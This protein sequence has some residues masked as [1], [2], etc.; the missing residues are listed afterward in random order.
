MLF[1]GSF[2]DYIYIII[3]LV[4]IVFSIYKG[5]QKNKARK[6]TPVAPE[7]ESEEKE[8]SSIFDSFLNKLMKEEEQVPYE[9]VEM[10]PTTDENTQVVHAENEKIFSY[11]DLAEESNYL[12]KT[13]VYEEQA[14]TKSTLNQE[15]KTHLK[16]PKTKPR[17]D[18]RKA[19]IYS[20]ILNRR[21]F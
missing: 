14:V 19:V 8:P 17:F 10:H 4:W 3:G 15:L 2:E 16:Q 20:E 7:S 12:K 18:L 1:K 5:A 11:D 13:A 6:Q 21:Y 9:P